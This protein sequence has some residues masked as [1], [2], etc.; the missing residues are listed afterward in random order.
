MFL[1]SSS[2]IMNYPKPALFYEVNDDNYF[3]N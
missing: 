1:L 2:I 3:F